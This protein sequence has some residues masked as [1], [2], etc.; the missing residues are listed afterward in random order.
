[1][2]RRK[3]R[4]WAY[5]AQEAT[6]LA[7]IGCSPA[8]IAAYIDV[9]KSTVTRW[10]AKGKLKVAH[11]VVDVSTVVRAKK[12]PAEWA[13]AIRDEFDLSE[14]DDQLVTLAEAALLMSQDPNAKRSERLN[15]IR[16]FPSIVT[17][18]ALAGRRAQAE[19]PPVAEPKVAIAAAAAVKVAT[20]NPKVR[21]RSSADPRTSFMR[22]VK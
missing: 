19:Q 8:E 9:D 2:T 3:T 21:R 12:T 6:R 15:A 4:A 14:T 5:V 1:M 13:T 17:K 10:I 7:A 16:T 18:L 11:K 20:K 22:I